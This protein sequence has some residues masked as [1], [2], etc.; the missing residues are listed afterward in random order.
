MN[1]VH[2]P[3]ILIF[4]LV[5]PNP[6][7]FNENSCVVP[8]NSAIEFKS[9]VKNVISKLDIFGLGTSPLSENKIFAFFINVVNF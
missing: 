1:R 7:T 9:G 8:F 4:E 3:L 5:K 6:D 2:S